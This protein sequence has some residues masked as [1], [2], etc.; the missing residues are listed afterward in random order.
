MKNEYLKDTYN[1]SLPIWIGKWSNIENG[2]GLVPRT[3]SFLFFTQDRGDL[4][5]VPSPVLYFFDFE[6]PG[7]TE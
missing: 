7:Q 4:S 5:R 1:K 2:V 3:H 6:L